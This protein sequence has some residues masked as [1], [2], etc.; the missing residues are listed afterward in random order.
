MTQ[1]LPRTSTRCGV[2]GKRRAVHRHHLVKQQ[3]IR[4]RW[5]SLRYRDAGKAPY[6]LTSVLNDPRLYILVCGFD[7]CHREETPVPIPAG[8][9]DA[10]RDYELEPDLPRWLAEQTLTPRSD[11]NG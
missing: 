9:W 3:R 6:K 4:R 7:G 5:R 1:S 10:V 11:L 2:C 8:F